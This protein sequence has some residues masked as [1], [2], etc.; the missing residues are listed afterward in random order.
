MA[1][2]ESVIEWGRILDEFPSLSLF[3]LNGIT[4][5]DVRQGAIG[6]CWFMAGASAV[7]EVSGRLEHVFLNNEN[8]VSQTGIYGVNIYTLG[9][10]HT[11]LIDDWLPLRQSN[12]GL[13]TF[14]AHIGDDNS[15]WAAV[16]E[17]SLAKYYGNYQHLEGGNPVKSVRTLTG[18]PYLMHFHRGGERYGKPNMQVEELW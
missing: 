3:G 15:I 1:S 6:N 11:I 4:P 5:A 12:D 13:K 9:V 8:R 7:A 18:A 16:L 14:F 10:P 17:K 2:Y